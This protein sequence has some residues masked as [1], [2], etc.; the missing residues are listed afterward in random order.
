MNRLN[1]SFIA[2]NTYW[3]KALKFVYQIA[4]LSSVTAQYPI[5]RM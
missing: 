2:Y 1:C 5:K 3:E 4:G